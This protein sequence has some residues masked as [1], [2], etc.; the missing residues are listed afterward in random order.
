MLPSQH[1]RFTESSSQ[2]EASP[3]HRSPCH[4]PC[5]G[6]ETWGCRFLLKLA[7]FWEFLQ[8]SKSSSAASEVTSWDYYCSELR[9]LH[10][11]FLCCTTFSRSVLHPMN[12]GK[13]V[14]PILS[15]PSSFHRWV[16]LPNT[17]LFK[18]QTTTVTARKTRTTVPVLCEMPLLWPDK[19]K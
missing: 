8:E 7:L 16:L 19:R 14:F 9:L 10:L 5:L 12:S 13:P 6:W 2:V 4:V 15:I 17:A 1:N 11:S 3:D 18:E